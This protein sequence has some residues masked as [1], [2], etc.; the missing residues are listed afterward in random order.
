SPYQQLDHGVKKIKIE[1]ELEE[2]LRTC[3]LDTVWSEAVQAVV[4]SKDF[5]SALNNAPAATDEYREAIARAFVAQAIWIVRNRRKLPDEESPVRAQDRDRL[6]ELLLEQFGGHRSVR[7][8]LA[9]QVIGRPGTFFIRRNRS[10]YSESAYQ[11]VGDI[12]L[13]QAH[14]ESIQEFIL[15]KIKAAKPPVILLAHSL[16]G[17]ACVDLLILES[18]PEV[19]LLVTAGS[20]SPLFYEMGALSSLESRK[21]LPEH[22]PKHWLHIYDP[23]DFLG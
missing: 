6:I 5:K 7:G 15:E 22:F 2:L 17:I 16:G 3:G 8:W 19:K 23:S 18:L 13:Y 1:G 9:K 21:P 11:G 20:Q 4:S 14:G 12:L 10:E